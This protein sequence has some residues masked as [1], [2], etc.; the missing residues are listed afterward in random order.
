M[1]QISMSGHKGMVFAGAPESG[2]LRWNEEDLTTPILP[3]FFHNDFEACRPDST[4]TFP[5]PVWRSLTLDREQA[6][7]EPPQASHRLYWAGVEAPVASYDPVETS[8]FTTSDVSFVSP[9]PD[10]PGGDAPSSS[11]ETDDETL[12]QFYEHSYAVHEDIPSSQIISPAEPREAAFLSSLESSTFLSVDATAGHPTL[13][14]RIAPCSGRL[15]NLSDIPSATYLRSITPQTMTLNLIVGVISMPQPRSIKT[16]RGGRVI[17]LVEMLVGDETK[18]GFGINV[19]LPSPDYAKGRA[20]D[21]DGMRSMIGGLRPQDV[22]LVRNVAL[23]SFRGKVYGQSL[24]RNMTKLDLLFRNAVDREDD[25]GAYDDRQLDEADE[26]EPQAAKAKRVREWV[27]KFV[28]AGVRQPPVQE[29]RRPMKDR[30]AQGDQEQILP[31]DT[32]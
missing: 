24:R 27:M 2:T 1:N 7:S 28:G 11:N 25:V 10:G 8:F 3:C 23:G 14:L 15:S 32:Q 12:S 29:S 13:P 26:T 31:P 6:S 18:A 19:W 9:D 5:K 30:R 4:S 22:V 17:E 16:R 21:S 20:S